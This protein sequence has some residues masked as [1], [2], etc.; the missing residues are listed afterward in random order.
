MMEIGQ[1]STV[2]RQ[3]HVWVS[4]GLRIQV[5]PNDS[6][7][8]YTPFQLFHRQWHNHVIYHF[9]LLNDIIVLSEFSKD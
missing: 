6:N 2:H 5:T 3:I 9:K 7:R 1:S 8:L 4:E